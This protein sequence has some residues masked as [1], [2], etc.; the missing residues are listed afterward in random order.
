MQVE[1]AQRALDGEGGRGF[2]GR[3]IGRTRACERK[4][5]VIDR[6]EYYCR[7]DTKI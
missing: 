4:V 1:A 5:V 2:Q 3:R 6:Q 7:Q